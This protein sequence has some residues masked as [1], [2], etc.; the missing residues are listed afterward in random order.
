MTMA[1]DDTRSRLLQPKPFIIGLYG[2]P[3]SG[4]SYLLQM[5]G[6]TLN[7][8][9][10]K[11][12]EGSAM[13]E[14]LVPGGLNVF[15]E[16]PYDDKVVWRGQA[17]KAIVEE[18]REKNVVGIVAG[19]LMFW[20]EMNDDEEG[21]IE[22]VWTVHD[23]LSYDYIVYL[24]QPPQLVVERRARDNQRHRPFVT[25]AHIQKWQTAEIKRLLQIHRQHK[26]GFEAVMCPHD[27][28]K[29]IMSIVR[30][31]SLDIHA[32]TVAARDALDK[33]FRANANDHVVL[34]FDADRTL[35]PQ[36]SGSLID[37]G[38]CNG[39]DDDM[40]GWNKF[41]FSTE[42][43]T[44]RAFKLSTILCEKYFTHDE[45]ERVCGGVSQLIELYPPMKW[46]LHS[47]RENIPRGIKVFIFTCGMRA[48]WHKVLQRE[49]LAESVTIIGGGRF[50]DG[51]FVT[52][53]VKED[54]ISHLQEQ[55][56]HRK[57][58]VY[59]FGDSPLDLGMLAKADHAFVIVGDEATRSKTMDKAL[60]DSLAT[61]S[62][63]FA[64]QIIFDN[65]C[66]RLDHTQLPVTTSQEVYASV[67]E[68]VSS[69][70]REPSLLLS[71]LSSQSGD[72][73]TR[74]RHFT[75]AEA[76]MLLTTPTRHA[77]LNGPR[78][79]EA[80]HRIG[81][82]LG[83]QVITSIVG[84]EPYLIPHVQNRTTTGHC[85]REEDQ[86]VIVAILRGGEPMALGINDAFPRAMF[87]H[88]REA[89][90]LKP[91]HI[92]NRSTIILVDSVINS[93][94]TVQQFVRHVREVKA[95]PATPAA[96][97]TADDSLRASTTTDPSRIGSP[98]GTMA[99][100]IGGDAIRI[101]VVTAV[102]QADAIQ[103]AALP[104][105]GGLMAQMLN[106]DTNTWLVALR[107]STNKFT[108][109]GGTDTGNRLFNTTVLD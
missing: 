83:L 20:D 82:Y 35:A 75:D 23:Q 86:T 90:D 6:D 98:S 29:T 55:V 36:D 96:V 45:F 53:E 61:K 106:E 50:S 66:P 47:V 26:I 105:G 68:T 94:T 52:P 101:I 46:L 49:G 9:T 43:Y 28:M 34:V 54:L 37:A 64:K 81:Y 62:I 10:C 39:M 93:G 56:G 69:K 17:M 24:D 5:L 80:H 108:G 77:G 100:N 71:L 85:L 88:A 27:A 16:L 103:I 41:L 42:G 97:G 72:W 51:L 91:C 18:C 63:L 109:R 4:K 48:I 102:L 95:A 38:I 25:A 67:H 44:D 59:A 11:V 2:V 58:V 21:T 107:V 22:E 30:F 70:A 104:A 78:L 31:V 1:T 74:F 60:A 33:T 84:V 32:N 57:A 15:K 65:A 79:R 13:L 89:A 19:H 14:S 12:F 76:S 73:T 92:C 7:S 3:G 99:G 40:P 87:V 8:S